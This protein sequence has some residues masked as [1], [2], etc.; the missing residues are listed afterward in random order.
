MFLKKV[1][2]QDYEFV[3]NPDLDPETVDFGEVG[4][5][6]RIN[7][8]VVMDAAGFHYDYNDIIRWQVL[9]GGRFNT[10]NLAEAQIDGGEFSIRSA[11]PRNVNTVFAATYLH[12]DINN[13]GPL[14]YVPEWRFFVGAE[15]TYRRTTYGFEMRHV[16]KTDTV[17][18]YQNDAPD[19]FTVMN[20]RIA[21]QFRQS[22]RLSLHVE[23][24]TNVQY[25]EME[26][27]RMPPRTYRVE[28]LYDFDFRKQ[29]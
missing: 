25:E 26:R 22:T 16:A 1:G 21:F 14:T 6:C 12:T 10:E 29:D 5:N 2:T 11:W 7:D 9:A 18:F 13:E 27:Y 17:V 24:L 28:L 4:V 8:H 3:P 20:A 19:A 15:Y 23:N